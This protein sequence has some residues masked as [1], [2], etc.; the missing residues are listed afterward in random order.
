MK[1]FRREAFSFLFLG[2][3]CCAASAQPKDAGSPS[4]VISNV[5]RGAPCGIAWIVNDDSAFVMDTGGPYVA[6][7][8]AP[9]DSYHFYKFTHEGAN[10]VFEWGRVGNNAVGRISSDQATDLDLILSSGWPHWTSDFTGT[11]DGATGTATSGGGQINW[12]LKTSPAPKSSSSSAVTISLVPNSPVKLVAG[13]G[14]LPAFAAVDSILETARQKYAANRPQASGDWGDFIGAIA[15]NMNNSR[16]YANDNHML[17]H[18]VSR[19]W[20][21]AN[22]PFGLPDPHPNGSPYFCWDSFFTANLAALDDPVTARNTVR[23]ILSCQSPEGLVPNYGHWLGNASMDRSQPPVGSLCVWKMHQRYPDDLDFLK[24]VYPKF[25]LWHDWW[26]KYRNAKG[27]GLLEWGSSSGHYQDAQYE[28]GWDDNLHYKGAGMK[29]T[30][31]NCYSVDLSAMWAMDAHYLAL[32]ADTLGQTEDAARFRK[33][34]AEMNKRI[35]DKLW[36]DELNAYCSRFWDDAETYVPADPSTYGAG[37]DGEYFSDENLQTS[38]GTKHDDKLDFNWN[39]K[40]P[41]PGMTSGDNW[42]ARWKGVFTAPANGTYRFIMASDDGSRVIVDGKTI[43]EDWGVH[44]AQE[45]SSDVSLTQGQAVP[46]VIEYFQRAQGSELH[47]FVGQVAS[48]H[49]AFLTRLTP[50]NFYPLSSGAP[51]ADRAKRVLS[52][53]TDP[54]RFWGPYVLPTLAYND[55]DWHIQEYWRGDIWG[56]TNYI[57]W[58]GIK[59]YASSGQITQYADR[60]VQLFMHEWLAKGVCGENYLSTDGTQNHDPHYTWGALLNLIGLEGIVDIDDAGQIVLNGTLDKT[61]TLTHIPLLGK[62]F[63][64]KVTPGSTELIQ[65]GKV[66]LTAKGGIVR[67]FLK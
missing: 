60:N 9:D 1:L 4:V 53:L 49:G 30:T 44:G 16:L 36:N 5:L 39:E 41:L 25:V 62:I 66:V 43:I 34:E 27:D 32:L 11:P 52:V 28:T 2:A 23:A 35:N 67:A 40:P 65:D 59:K 37:F 57:T 42:S 24:E 63:D 61:V 29:G 21:W 22:P 55:P 19:G 48:T 47:F 26:T 3:F 54:A 17:A 56:P 7:T 31:M 46:V 45:K 14:D 64:V 51:D 18:S 15:D 20:T 58:V 33:D 10:V 50:M 13:L 38:A 6:G 8:A 12:T